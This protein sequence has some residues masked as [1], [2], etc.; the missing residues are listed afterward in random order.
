M[1]SSCPTRIESAVTSGLVQDLGTLVLDLGTGAHGFSLITAEEMLGT[2]GPRVFCVCPTRIESAVT[3]GL[4]QELHMQLLSRGTVVRKH[5][6]E[7]QL[8]PFF[9]QVVRRHILSIIF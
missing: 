2:S 6:W 1:S 5:S 8:G 4:V 9:L 7:S 3:C